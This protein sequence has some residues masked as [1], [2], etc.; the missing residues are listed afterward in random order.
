[1]FPISF[2]AGLQGFLFPLL[3]LLVQPVSHLFQGISHLKSLMAF[4]TSASVIV[5][6]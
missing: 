4:A 1:M 5:G 2:Y 3:P 6:C